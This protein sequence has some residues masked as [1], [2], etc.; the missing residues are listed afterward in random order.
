MISRKHT[1]T[2]IHTNVHNDAHTYT[3]THTHRQTRTRAHTHT[4]THIE[5]YGKRRGDLLDINTGFII[6]LLLLLLKDKMKLKTKTTQ[7]R[8]PVT[9]GDILYIIS[10][11]THLL[12]LLH[13]KTINDRTTAQILQCCYFMSIFK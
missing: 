4:H 8:V 5:E 9:Y 3:H 10:L 13:S 1:H 12:L 11:Y 7:T 2:Q 6:L